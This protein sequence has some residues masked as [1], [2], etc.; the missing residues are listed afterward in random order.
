VESYF[1]YPRLICPRC[2]RRFFLPD[3]AWHWLARINPTQRK[4]LH[5]GLSLDHP[6]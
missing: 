1:I 3:G 5:C 2:Q 4:C 6:R